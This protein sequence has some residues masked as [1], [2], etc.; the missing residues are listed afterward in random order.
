MRKLAVHDT[1]FNNAA[2]SREI[3]IF[4]HSM[5]ENYWWCWHGCVR[6]VN[7]NTHLSPQSRCGAFKSIHRWQN[8]RIARSDKI[9]ICATTHV[10]HIRFELQIYC[11]SPALLLTCK[12]LEKRHQVNATCSKYFLIKKYSLLWHHFCRQNLNISHTFINNILRLQWNIFHIFYIQVARLIILYM[13][14]GTA[15]ESFLVCG[16][17]CTAN[18]ALLC[19]AALSSISFSL[20]IDLPHAICIYEHQCCR[21]L[22]FI[23]SFTTF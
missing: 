4:S 14:F 12:S 18:H 10:I 17:N 22:A 1:Y 7:C 3:R 11:C 15:A 20:R 23:A 19:K 13:I 21:Q 16:G 2:R 9:C 5:Q 8:Y 6:D